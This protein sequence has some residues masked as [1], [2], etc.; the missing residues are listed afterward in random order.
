MVTIT[1]VA[2]K[3][4]VSP[5]TAS[6]ALNGRSEVKEKTRERVLKAAKELNYIPNKLAQ[7]FRNGKT[8]TI[9]VITNEAIESFLYTINRSRD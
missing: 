9:T 4:G 8:N 3:A 1:E 2:K 6:Y 5:T 7:S